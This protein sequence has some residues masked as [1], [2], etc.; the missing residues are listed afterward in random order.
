M[1]ACNG[2]DRGCNIT[3]P[4]KR[5]DF[6]LVSAGVDRQPTGVGGDADMS[7]RSQ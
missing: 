4:R 5:A 2:T 1:P 3:L 7:A 6:P